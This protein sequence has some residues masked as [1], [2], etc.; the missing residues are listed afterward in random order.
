M[1]NEDPKVIAE[2]KRGDRNLVKLECKIGEFIADIIGEAS[3]ATLKVI[4]K[5]ISERLPNKPQMH[6][7]FFRALSEKVCMEKIFCLI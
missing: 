6:D 7:N 3:T 1:K 2:K 5:N 4:K